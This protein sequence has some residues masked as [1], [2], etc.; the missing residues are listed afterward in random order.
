MVRSTVQFLR[1]A[2]RYTHTADKFISLAI[3]F[4]RRRLSFISFSFIG[5]PAYHQQSSTWHRYSRRQTGSIN[6]LNF[7]TNFLLRLIK[8]RELYVIGDM[9]R[10]FSIW[11]FGC[12]LYFAFSLHVNYADWNCISLYHL[13]SLYT[14]YIETS[15]S[16]SKLSIISEHVNMNAR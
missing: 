9:E 8:M 15:I 12:L 5:K 13:P 4:I 16:N 1:R 11:L 6:H 7:S 10:E 3:R 14:K 2:V